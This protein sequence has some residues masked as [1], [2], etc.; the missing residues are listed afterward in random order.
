MATS[1]VAYLSTFDFLQQTALEKF[2][3]FLDSQPLLHYAHRYWGFHSKTCYDEGRL[4][5]TVSTF[6]AQ[7]DIYLYFFDGYWFDVLEPCHVAAC[8]G[9]PDTLQATSEWVNQVTRRLRLT[10][11]ILASANG[12]KAIV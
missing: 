8:Y 1:C 12:H 9:L 2:D 10:P 4:P 3:E 6:V 7:L 11:L 5:A